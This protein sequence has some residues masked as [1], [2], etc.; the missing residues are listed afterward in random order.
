[1]YEISSFGR[2]RRG[3]RMQSTKT[4]QN[5]YVRY[6]LHGQG[7][8]HRM[9]AHVLVAKAFI[10]NPDNKPQVDHINRQ[11]NDNHKA[12]L[13]WAT[14]LENGRN[15]TMGKNFRTTRSVDQLSLEGNLIKTFPSA[16]EAGDEFGIWSSR[17][18][19]CCTGKVKTASGYRWRY[20]PQP[21]LPN[22]IWK[23]YHLEGLPIEVSSNGRIRSASHGI[24][25]GCIDS[26][27]YVIVLKTRVHRLVCEAFKGGDKQ[28]GQTMVNHKDG[29]RTNNHIDNL[30]W[31]TPAQ[32]SQHAFAHG[33]SK[34]RKR[35]IEQLDEFGEVIFTFD[36]ITSATKAL[37][38]TWSVI[39]R[40]IRKGENLCF[41]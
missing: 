22:E 9:Y 40:K 37:D 39:T 29:T 2:L 26:D 13:R 35:K 28:E 6:G 20:T 34:V 31:A 3:K 33:G 30:E 17:I 18:S 12:N 21:D 11:R 1:M 15:R 24:Y 23:E 16:I 36:S 5:G 25:K 32:N 19:E 38:L 8:R 41:V 10:D 7:Q 4:T 27:G 14:F